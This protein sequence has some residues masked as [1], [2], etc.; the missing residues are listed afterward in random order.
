M[1]P[2]TGVL[3][4]TKGVGRMKK[5]LCLAIIAFM[6]SG[7]AISDKKNKLAVAAVAGGV[8]GGFLAFSAFGPGTAGILGAMA[9]GGVS[10]GAAYL[11]TE[12][13]LRREERASLRD[14]TYQTLQYGQEGEESVWTG[15]QSGA[16]AK[17]MPLKTFR[18]QAG[19]LC[20]DFVVVFDIGRTRESIK[21]TACQGID[22][23][24]QTV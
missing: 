5:I 6:L 2:G 3:F 8:A 24:W 10:A 12:E 7:C 18:D 11:V 13:A 14:A 17:I 15:P 20:R 16:S 1:P 23:S 4:C 9:I 19:R 21:R 22:G